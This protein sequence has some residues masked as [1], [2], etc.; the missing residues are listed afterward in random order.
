MSD[1]VAQWA[2]EQDLVRLEI[3]RIVRGRALQALTDKPQPASPR[4]SAVQKLVDEHRRDHVALCRR[5][6]QLA[7]LRSSLCAWR[8]SCSVVERV[9]RV[10]KGLRIETVLTYPDGGSIDLYLADGMLTDLGETAGMLVNQGISWT[11]EALNQVT[12][13]LQPYEVVSLSDASLRVE[14]TPGADRLQSSMV[15]L[16]LACRDVAHEL[17]RAARA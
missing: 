17:T 7:P 14:P 3:M 15:A 1:H 8:G 6:G 12:R 13:L 11:V 10:P 9:E 2:L 5:C 4:V 16:A